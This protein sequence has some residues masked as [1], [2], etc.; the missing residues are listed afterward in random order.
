LFSRKKVVYAV[1][2]VCFALG[3]SAPAFAGK[4]SG[5]GNN[6]AS[7]SFAGSTS[8]SAASQP[9][10]GDTVGFAVTANVKPS[11]LYNLMVRNRCT[12]N[13]TVMWVDDEPVLSGQASP[14]TFGWN[15]G[16][17][18]QCTAYVWLFPDSETAL[19]GGSMSYSVAGS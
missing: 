1:I 3:A 10:A 15:G 4:G 16:G 14:F 12:Q 5:G 11:D 17:A 19:R 8:F 9:K 13:G 2:A 7:I 18:A 6:T